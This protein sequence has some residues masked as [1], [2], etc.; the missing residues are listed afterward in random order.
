MNQFVYICFVCTVWSTTI[1]NL[2]PPKNYCILLKIIHRY[3]L[4]IAFNL[5]RCA[6]GE[7]GKFEYLQSHNSKF[8]TCCYAHNINKHIEYLTDPSENYVRKT[9]WIT[10]RK[11]KKNQY[12][13]TSHTHTRRQTGAKDGQEKKG[14]AEKDLTTDVPMRPRRDGNHVWSGATKTANER[15]SCCR[16]LV[17]RCS[18]RSAR[19]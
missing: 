5:I 13:R 6:T 16:K 11:S 8:P 19:N 14:K 2:E 12:A 4:Y 10:I 9:I 18:S 7:N 17:A 3:R 1:E 15:V